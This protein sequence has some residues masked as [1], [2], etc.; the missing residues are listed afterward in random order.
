MVETR[1]LPLLMKAVDFLFDQGAKILEARRARA[2]E[3]DGDAASHQDSGEAVV[4]PGDRA[5]IVSRDDAIARRIGARRWADAEGHVEHLMELIAIHTEHYYSAEKALAKWGSDMAPPILGHRLAD[6]E[7]KIAE[8]HEALR[9]AL[10]E[11]Y[12]ADV[13]PERSG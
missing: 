13:R 9:L 4:P 5:V 3:A 12:D 7:T 6:A 10:G 1:T 11:V 8:L 2:A